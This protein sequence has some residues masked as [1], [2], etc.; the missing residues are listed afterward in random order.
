MAARQRP[1]VLV[2][3]VGE[4]ARAANWG[5]AGY[6]RD[7]TPRLR[8]LPVLDFGTVAACGT[9]TETSLPCMFAPVGRRDYDAARIRGQE[10]LLHVLN[11]AGVA[12]HWRDNQSGCKGVCDGLPG[13]RPTPATAPGLCQ[14]DRCLDE[15]LIHD[16]DQRL[17]K[18]GTAPSTQVW[19]LHMLG[20]HGPAYFRRYPPTFA[21]FE[22]ACRDEDL[23]LCT[24]QSIVNAYDNALRYT[25]EVLARTVERL[26]AHAGSVDS[27]LLYVSDHGESLGE[28][29]L[30]LH[31]LPYSI[32]PD[33]QKQVPMVFWSSNGFESAAGLQRGC[34]QGPLRQ[35]AQA[36]GVTHDN[37]FHTVL[38]LMDVR[39]AVHE[40][41]LDLVAPC[42]SATASLP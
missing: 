12:V 4:T 35:R 30:Y 42:R 24:P 28:M 19:V 33:V 41:Q 22:P 27:A 34:L 23:G 7:T 36:G 31:G 6:A 11:R 38:G 21:A 16:L 15:A 25:D 32:A 18:L 26:T 3:V 9:N 40:P 20:N 29:G 13:D 39:T 17:A 10:S 2:L 14:G 37:L 8:A 1:L 5:L